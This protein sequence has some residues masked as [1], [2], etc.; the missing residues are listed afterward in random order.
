[1]LKDPLHDREMKPRSV[2]LPIWKL[3][4]E[5]QGTSGKAQAARRV[6]RQWWVARLVDLARA[7]RSGPGLLLRYSWGEGG[8]VETTGTLF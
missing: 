6:M 1:M 7:K 5:G 3:P 8:V 2:S 4:T